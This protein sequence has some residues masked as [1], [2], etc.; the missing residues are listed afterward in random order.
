MIEIKIKSGR[1]VYY[2]INK[3]PHFGRLKVTN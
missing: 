1:L 3:Y 2:N